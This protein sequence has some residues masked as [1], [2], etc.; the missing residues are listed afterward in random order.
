M[1]RERV[2][3]SAE[4]VQLRNIKNISQSLFSLNLVSEHRE[5]KSGSGRPKTRGET[6]FSLTSSV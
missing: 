3:N 5:K 2:V 4:V 1:R 6:R